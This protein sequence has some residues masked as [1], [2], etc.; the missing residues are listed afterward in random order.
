MKLWKIT[1]SE[2]QILKWFIIILKPPFISPDWFVVK[3][4]WKGSICWSGMCLFIHQAALRDK[5][6]HTSWWELKNNMLASIWPYNTSSSAL[7][8]M[9][10]GHSGLQGYIRLHIMTAGHGKWNIWS[11][12]A[13]F[14]HVCKMIS[15]NDFGDKYSRQMIY[16]LLT[17]HYV[18]RLIKHWE[19][20]K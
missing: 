4:W 18:T 17:L 2:D 16:H 10:N 14:Y 9:R 19:M 11:R 5:A 13:H 7:S 3:I 20:V 8:N 6:V 12:W 1:F 15:L